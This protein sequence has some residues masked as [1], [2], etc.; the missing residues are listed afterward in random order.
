M[1]QSKL[2]LHNGNAAW[3]IIDSD[4]LLQEAQFKRRNLTNVVLQGMR[5]V[6]SQHGVRHHQNASYVTAQTRYAVRGL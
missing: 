1:T 2:I 5:F 3:T 6:D 4:S